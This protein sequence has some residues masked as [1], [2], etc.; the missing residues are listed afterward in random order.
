MS[1]PSGC[2]SVLYPTPKGRDRSGAH[3]PLRSAG[4]V[5]WEAL[6]A[7]VEILTLWVDFRLDEGRSSGRGMLAFVQSEITLDIASRAGV[8]KACSTASLRSV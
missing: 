4:S 5:M 7:M 1:A 8:A 6:S 3:R 2:V